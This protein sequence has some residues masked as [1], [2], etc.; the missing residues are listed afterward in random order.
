MLDINLFF[1]MKMFVSKQK[2][3]SVFT[4][5]P[6]RCKLFIDDIPVEQ[7]MQFRYQGV[8]IFLTTTS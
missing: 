1:L 2:K 7:V 3:L 5:N 8:N 6:I 4:K